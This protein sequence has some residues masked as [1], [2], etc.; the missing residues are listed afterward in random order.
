MTYP[1][2]AWTASK[3][4]QRSNS[5]DRP[6]FGELRRKQERSLFLVQVEEDPAEFV[7]QLSRDPW[8]ASVESAA[9]ER[10]HALRVETSDLDAAEGELPR[11]VYESGLTML[12][13]ELMSASPE[14]VSMEL[15]GP[16][17]GN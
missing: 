3:T 5:F 1:S 15:A 14:D 7:A 11:L 6:S 8:V 13:Y 12:K 9:T 4:E 10:L 2:S 17:G 16:G